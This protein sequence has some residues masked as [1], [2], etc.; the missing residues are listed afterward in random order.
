ML[1]GDLAAQNLL[2][3]SNRLDALIDWGDAAWGPPT[4]EFAKLPLKQVAATLPAYAAR[5]GRTNVEA[6]ALWFRR[7]APGVVIGAEVNQKA[8]C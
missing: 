4:M 5:T 6:A 7:G 1:H 2:A 8:G 3:T